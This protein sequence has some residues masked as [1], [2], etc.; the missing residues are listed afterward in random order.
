[1]KK[2]A[3]K[4]I[5][6]LGILFSIIAVYIIAGRIDFSKT[7]GLIK[8]VNPLLFLLLIV[9]YLSTYLFRT[10]RWKLMLSNFEAIPFKTLLQ[11][12]VVGFAGNNIIPARGG[13][14]LRMEY[15]SR[16]TTINRIAALTSVLTEKVLDGLTL[17]AI[18]L[19]S[20][21]IHQEFWE[22]DWFKTL[23]I[24]VTVLFITLIVGLIIV[25]QYC[26]LIISILTK[27]KFPLLDL[28]SSILRKVQSALLFLKADISTIWILLLGAIIWLIEGGMYVIGIYAFKT[29]VDPITAGYLCLAIV[30][31]GLLVPSSPGYIGVFQA[32]TILALFLFGISEEMALSISILIHICQFV[33]ITI[34]GIIILL[35]NSLFYKKEAE[36]SD[37]FLEI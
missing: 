1:M 30:N 36:N 5:G 27:L 29:G 6:L 19:I 28:I 21:S 25:R 8:E 2:H 10:I 23:T 35:Q 20:A 7:A 31:F 18:L 17:V 4:I 33:P 3:K 12:V 32:M 9:V 11:A 15:L 34:W 26:E 14:L 24:T 37:S 13:E 16:K 22:I